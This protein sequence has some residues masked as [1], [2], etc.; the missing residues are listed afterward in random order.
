MK[1]PL[2]QCLAGRAYNS[3][4]QYELIQECASRFAEEKTYK[5]L[6]R[7]FT[8]PSSFAYRTLVDCG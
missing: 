6:V 7:P 8:R 2:P 4:N 3:E 5:L 1:L